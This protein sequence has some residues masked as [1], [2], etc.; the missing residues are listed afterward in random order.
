[1]KAAQHRV[2]LHAGLS[3]RVTTLFVVLGLLSSFSSPAE[4]ARKRVKSARIEKPKP[5][6]PALNK[7]DTAA[8]KEFSEFVAHL[9]K[10]RADRVCLRLNSCLLDPRANKLWSPED[11]VLK[12]YADCADLP[13]VLRAYFAYK[14][15]RPFQWTRVIRGKRYTGHNSPRDFIDYTNP[16][17]RSVPRLLRRVKRCVQSGFY[18]MSGDLEETD[19]YPVDV[20]P[21]FVTPGTVYYDPRGH[22]LIVYSV[23]E[24]GTVRMLAGHPDNTLTHTTLGP[25]FTIGRR[26]NGG[27]FRNWRHYTMTQTDPETFTFT[28]E[29]NAQIIARKGGLDPDAQYLKTYDVD[30]FKV[31]YFEWVRG[32]LS[33]RGLKIDPMQVF[34]EKIETLCND[35]QERVDAV[36]IA[37]NARIHLKEHP[38]MLPRNI[39]GTSGEWEVYSSPSRDARMKASVRHIHAWIRDVVGWAE[40]N[41]PRL[42]YKGDAFALSAEL[43]QRWQVH[44][45]SEA[46]QFVYRNSRDEPVALSLY[47]VMDRLFALSFDPYHCPEIRWGAKR[48]SDEYRSCRRDSRKWWFYRAERRLRNQIE[49]EYG[50]KTDFSFGPKRSPKIHISTLLEKVRKRLTDADDAQNRQGTTAVLEPEDEKI[51]TSTERAP[52]QE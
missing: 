21:A 26:H 15:K 2:R 12:V 46:C 9:G 36:Q 18:R 35:I 52:H 31:T 10:A 5:L 37:L 33:L 43:Q 49:R 51:E 16:D 45:G 8:E 30:G 23:E 11:R 27:G 28:R 22:V 20:R 40:R 1:M 19:T 29:T 25:Q 24:N 38:G 34:D 48:G 44:A 4:A 41:D 6:W 32:R 39:Y 17:V 13:Y 47:D 14:T 3:A 7:W 50:V 42:D